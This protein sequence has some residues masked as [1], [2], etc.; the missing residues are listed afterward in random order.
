M[1]FIFVNLIVLW[2]ITQFWRI[3]SLW[4]FLF[5][6][7]YLNLDGPPLDERHCS[8]SNISILMN[9]IT[10][11]LFVPYPISQSWWPSSW[12]TSLIP[13]QY[14]TGSEGEELSQQYEIPAVTLWMPKH[15]KDEAAHSS[16]QRCWPGSFGFLHLTT[17]SYHFSSTFTA[18]NLHMESRQLR[19][20]GKRKF[21]NKHTH[22]RCHL[23]STPSSSLSL[24]MK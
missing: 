18:T 8:T 16:S 1:N 14:F 6:M 17:F 12:W 11:N 21:W 23:L 2:P 20:A 9:F 5:Q 3:S 24:M 10:V 4:T 13:I 19:I 15:R 7:K 22:I